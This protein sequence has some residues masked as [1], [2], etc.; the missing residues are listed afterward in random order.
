M[1]KR[2][3][4]AAASQD[5]PENDHCCTVCTEGGLMTPRED[6]GQTC[7]I[8]DRTWYTQEEID[9]FPEF[10]EEEFNQF[11]AESNKELEEAKRKQRGRENLEA[12]WS[13]GGTISTELR[14]EKRHHHAKIIKH[15]SAELLLKNPRL[16]N[17]ALARHIFSLHNADLLEV[18][19]CKIREILGEIKPN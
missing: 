15:L 1:S 7:P 9:A 5:P 4:S 8:C 2:I 13:K 6:G 14:R 12:G 16:S 19:E 3:K 17:H 11:I 18:S 10:Y